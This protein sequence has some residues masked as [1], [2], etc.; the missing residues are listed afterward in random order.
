M[1][2]IDTHLDSAWN[3]WIWN[4]NLTR[5]VHEIR[6]TETGMNERTRA[7]GAPGSLRRSRHRARRRFSRDAASLSRS[8]RQKRICE[9]RDSQWADLEA[10][11]E[12]EN[13]PDQ[14]CRTHRAK[15]K[16]KSTMEV[17]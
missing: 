10:R 2:I 6:K 11:S 17:M 16:S 5:S 13:C 12:K 14:I 9:F 8:K 7:A 4:C 1:I 3:A 15:L